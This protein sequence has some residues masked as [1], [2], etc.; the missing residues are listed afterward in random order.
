MS[1][2]YS[3]ST[4]RYKVLHVC[5]L[6]YKNVHLTSESMR[7]FEQTRINPWCTEKEAEV[8]VLAEACIERSP[9]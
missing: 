3:I 8:D 9:S 4:I 2:L 5:E 7:G 1:S 6:H